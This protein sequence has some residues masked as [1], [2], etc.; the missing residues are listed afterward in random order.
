MFCTGRDL[1]NQNEIAGKLG[2]AWKCRLVSFGYSADIDYYAE[3]D[4]KVVAVVEIKRRNNPCSLYPTVYLSMRKWLALQMASVGFGVSGIFAVGFNDCIRY[5]QI[6]D[7]DPRK[8][9]IAGRGDVR[10]SNDIEPMI[11]VP[12]EAMKKLPE[13]W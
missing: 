5:A 13:S 11:E 1:E 7:V 9:I 4:G 3:R 6:R 2:A 10:A 12:I 8:M